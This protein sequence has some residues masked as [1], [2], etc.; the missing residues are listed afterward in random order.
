VIAFAGAQPSDDEIAAIV[1]A[2]A[3]IEAPARVPAPPPPPS[4]WKMAG[5]E[6]EPQDDRC[7]ARF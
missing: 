1:A 4:P 3:S 5:R 2:L 7:S 6:Y